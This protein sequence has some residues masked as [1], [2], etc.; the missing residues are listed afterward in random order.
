[1]A[2]W[3]CKKNSAAATLLSS[4]EKRNTEQVNRLPPSSS[5][6]PGTVFKLAFDLDL[7]PEIRTPSEAK[8][9]DGRTIM[10]LRFPSYLLVLLSPCG[11]GGGNDTVCPTSDHRFVMYWIACLPNPC[12]Y[13]LHTYVEESHDKNETV[14]RSITIIIGR[15][16]EEPRGNSC[17]L[18]TA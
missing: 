17:L 10:A 12:M 2:P 4:I 11:V 13:T 14:T 15:N 5:S 18:T 6:S 8:H 1:M 16:L 9:G 3:P 7:H